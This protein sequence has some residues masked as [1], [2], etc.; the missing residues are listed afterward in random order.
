MNPKPEELCFALTFVCL[1]C[2]RRGGGGGFL[3]TKYTNLIA[4]ALEVGNWLG[5]RTGP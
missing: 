1:C 4:E 3:F 2:R 5:G